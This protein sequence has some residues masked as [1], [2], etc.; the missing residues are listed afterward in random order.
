VTS[1]SLN[2]IVGYG[3]PSQLDTSGWKDHGTFA[4]PI[5]P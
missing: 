4:G 1:G 2:G 5:T 3:Q